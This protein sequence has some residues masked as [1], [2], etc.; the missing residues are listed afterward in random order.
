MPP[1]MRQGQGAC[2][3]VVYPASIRSNAAATIAAR[4]GVVFSSAK[5]GRAQPAQFG[6]LL[7][8]R[9]A[10]AG[11]PAAGERQDD[12]MPPDPA[13][14]VALDVLA[15]AG[16]RDRLDRDAGLLRHLAHD[17]LVQ[18]LAG[19]DHAARQRE[20]AGARAA[21]APRDQARGRRG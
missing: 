2:G 1:A 20:H 9:H 16:E 6:Q 12:E 13:V 15:I 11:N 21:R 4:P 14:V 8:Q 7:Q 19:L 18:R 5:P 10:F 17:R 3:G